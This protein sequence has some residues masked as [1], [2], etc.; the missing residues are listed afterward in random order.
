MSTMTD[1]VVCIRYD[2]LMM[3]NVS[4]NKM[5]RFTWAPS[6]PEVVVE[7]EEWFCFLDEVFELLR[8]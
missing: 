3:G 6:N 8:V 1:I 2:L 4:D 5:G 7:D